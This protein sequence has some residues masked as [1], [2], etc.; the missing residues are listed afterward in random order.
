[1]NGFKAVIPAAGGG[2][3]LRPHTQSVPKVLLEVA[4][5]PI[6]GH[7][8]DRLVPTGPAEV[9]VVLGAQGEMIESYLRQNYECRFRFVRQQEPLGLGH[10][11]YQAREC[12]AGEPALILLGDT[13][14]EMDMRAMVRANTIRTG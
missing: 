3:R 2:T 6:I 14:V 7:I 1:M 8:L 10:A 13:I 4:G 12:F 9:C 5:K 11:V